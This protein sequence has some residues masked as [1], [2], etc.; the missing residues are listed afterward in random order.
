MK[1][2]LPPKVKY[3]I[4]K[5]YECG[6][7]AYIVGGCV[8]DSI[9]G[10]EPNDFDITT[11]AKPN[12]IKEIFKNDKCLDS[13][14]KHGTISIILDKDIFEIT[15]YRIEGEYK[16]HRRPENVEYTHLLKEDLK[17]RDFTINSMAYN[18]KNNLVDLFGGISDIKHKII[19]T[20]G[21]PNER[22]REDGLRMI[23]AIRFSSKLNFKIEDNT[24]NAIYE[25][26][27]IIKNISIERI[28]DE[29]SKIILSDYP[30]NIIYLFETKLLNHLNISNEDNEK[31]LEILKSKLDI[32]SYIEKDLVKKLVALEYL[33]IES[34]LNCKR[35]YSALRFSNKINKNIEILLNLMTTVDISEIDKIKVKK[36]L[37][38][39]GIDLFKDYVD[40]ISKIKQDGISKD[41]IKRIN[42]ILAEI[43]END[44]CYTIKKLDINGKDII[45]LGYK[46]EQVGLI[47]NYLLNETIE[48]PKI[49]KKTILIE[50]IRLMKSNNFK[51]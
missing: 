10:I 44:E 6:Y 46:N 1:I 29:F 27:S 33:I 23:R 11:S 22:F 28:T 13:G 45:D 14:I 17:R 34:Q 12:E 25:N 37:N 51:K 39:V 24:L 48:N 35:I 8:R 18:E 21:N 30:N 20:V 9:I 47:L 5:I 7:E 15:T 32:L 31:R 26:A 19:K 49:N 42:S 4:D 3:I 40:I 16:D 50:K 2:I 38:N 41:N 43:E 36:I